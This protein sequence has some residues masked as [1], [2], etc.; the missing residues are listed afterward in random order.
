MMA[1]KKIRTQDSSSMI[2]RQNR[3]DDIIDKL[4]RGEIGP[5]QAEAEAARLGLSPLIQYPDAQNYDPMAQTF[6]TPLMAVAWIAFRVI[7]VV[8]N[9]MRDYRSGATTINKLGPAGTKPC[10]S[11]EEPGPASM[12]HLNMYGVT[13]GCSGTVIDEAIQSLT[14]ALQEKRIIASG[15]L[16]GIREEIDALQWADLRFFKD[17]DPEVASALGRQFQDVRFFRSEILNEWPAIKVHP[18]VNE[19]PS[20]SSDSQARDRPQRKKGKPAVQ[21]AQHRS[22]ILRILELAKREYPQKPGGP[23]MPMGLSYAKMAERL[24][25]L[26][27]IDRYGWSAID[28]ILRGAYPKMRELKIESPYAKKHA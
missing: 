24:E 5:A 15:I 25:S 1:D 11:V 4:H 26:R 7:A 27:G 12:R 13:R 23:P 17:E 22:D 10:Y 21:P 9:M 3:R 6:W 20:E 28:Q 19:R 14:K 18:G 16:A 2:D 8:R